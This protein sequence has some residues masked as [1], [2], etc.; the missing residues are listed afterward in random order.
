MAKKDIAEISEKN[1]HIN[2]FTLGVLRKNINLIGKNLRSMFHN[3][4]SYLLCLQLL[5]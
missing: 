4:Y 1:N 5:Q 3:N 2:I